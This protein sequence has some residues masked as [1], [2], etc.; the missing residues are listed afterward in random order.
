MLLFILTV[1]GTSS[2]LQESL[3]ALAGYGVA[4]YRLLPSLQAVYG[5]LS[6]MRF[7]RP[8]LD[9]LVKDFRDLGVA[10]STIGEHLKRAESEVVKRAVNNFS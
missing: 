1:M 9:N 8:A 4:G 10:R 7:S 6:T 3:P 2:N 5:V